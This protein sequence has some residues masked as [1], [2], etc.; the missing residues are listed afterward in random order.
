MQHF[1]IHLFH[2][3][4]DYLHLYLAIGFWSKS[5]QWSQMFS[6]IV[7][8]LEPEVKRILYTSLYVSL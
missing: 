2:I 4:S 7:E 6:F 5:K 1:N 8:K 3:I